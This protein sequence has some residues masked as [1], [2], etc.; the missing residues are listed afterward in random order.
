MSDHQ[1]DDDAPWPD[2]APAWLDEDAAQAPPLS[3]ISGEE[4]G[5]PPE[6]DPWAG[7]P[8]T[9]EATPRAEAPAA[10]EAEVAADPA[11]LT[12]LL[13]TRFGHPG[14]RTGQEAVVRH[15]AA[16]KD[17]LVVMP[18]GAGKSL[19][20]Q[21]PALARGGLT[22]VV[23]PLI[24]LMKDQ[25]D[26]LREV[27]V[28]AAYV[29]SS[30]DPSERQAVMEDAE[31]GRLT[32]LYIAPERFRSKGFARRVGNLTVGLF[33]IDEAHCLSQWG[34]DF[35][36][37]YLRLGK[38]RES[39]GTPPTVALTATATREVREDI[40]K[41][42]ELRDPEVFVTGFDRPN[43]RVDVEPCHSKR[44]KDLLVVDLIRSGPL[45]AIVYCATRKSVDRVSEALREAG[46]RGVERYHGGMGSEARTRV[47][48]DFMAGRV[49]VVA[50]TNAFG[51]GIDKED[52]RLVVHYE[53]PRTLEA[54]YQEI[55]R[56]GRD[57]KPA[58]A[59]LLFRPQ[60]RHVQ[61]FLIDQNH[62]PEWAVTAV[63]DALQAT[64]ENP[65]FR[66][67]RALAEA[68]TGS[69][70]ERMVGT[71]MQVLDKEG[72]LRR[73]PIREGLAEIEFLKGASAAPRREGLPKKLWE[74]LEELRLAGGHPFEAGP[75]A[76]ASPGG[77]NSVPVHLPTLV[78]ALGVERWRSFWRSTPSWTSTSRPTRPAASASST[79]ST[80]SSTSPAPGC[81][82]GQ[83]CGATSVTMPR[84]IAAIAVTT[85]TAEPGHGARPSSSPVRRRPWSA[86]CSAAT[87][88][89]AAE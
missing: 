1:P 51:M 42:L 50:A 80:A 13:S 11:R 77:G 85:A 65:V 73:L 82:A 59:V 49:Q 40:L 53:V 38:A 88:A 84:R 35:R 19:C 15:V 29:N 81:A 66:S 33:V 86:R 24:A 46:V 41:V 78:G 5:G 21:L 31:N 7:S 25:V 23:S 2:E 70:T 54:Y 37:D 32:L 12:E 9:A 17:A 60:D 57:G 6:E 39:L 4:A 36:P 3:M 52:L 18:T 14:F 58:R 87:P 67:H 71:A 79:S 62:P 69:L 76:D 75:V 55:G 61:E 34:H 74:A 89:C 20:Y 30:L 63:W 47:Q 26:A 64:G 44:D 45:P 48:D 68:V 10:V 27:G 8:A 43:L 28:A 56:A 16:G 72:F 22:I 83:P